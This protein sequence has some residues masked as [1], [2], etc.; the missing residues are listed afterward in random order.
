MLRSW[1]KNQVNFKTFTLNL[2]NIVF[3]I[4]IYYLTKQQLENTNYKRTRMHLNQVRQAFFPELEEALHQDILIKRQAGTVINGTYI[5]TKARLIAQEL[6]LTNFI[7]SRRW[8]MNFLKRH[9]LV[10]R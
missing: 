7:G 3:I 8:L 6:S 10:L 2:I 4:Y 9:N 5:L 1:I